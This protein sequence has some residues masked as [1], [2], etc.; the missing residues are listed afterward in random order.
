[1]QLPSEIYLQ[2]AIQPVAS[3]PAISAVDREL[4]FVPT[5]PGEET[6]GGS[7]VGEAPV[8]GCLWLL[9]VCCVIYGLYMRGDIFTHKQK[10]NNQSL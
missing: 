1:V 9:I 10:T 5:P 4:L 3:A 6:G 7:G 8:T 2:T